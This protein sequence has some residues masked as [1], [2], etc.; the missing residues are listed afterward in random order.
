MWYDDDAVPALLVLVVVGTSSNR[1]RT[2]KCSVIAVIFLSI[3]CDNFD[4]TNPL[5]KPLHQHAD[6]EQQQERF[7]KNDTYLKFIHEN[8]YIIYKVFKTAAAVCVPTV[9]T[10]FSENKYSKKLRPPLLWLRVVL[11]APKRC[12]LVQWPHWIVHY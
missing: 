4:A 12:F 10:V 5:S 6:D 11:V 8:S 2:K 1:T 7:L 9:K 3:R